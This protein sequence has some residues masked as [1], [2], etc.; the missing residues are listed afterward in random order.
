MESLNLRGVPAQT[1]SPAMQA[2]CHTV[3]H[4]G[5]AQIAPILILIFKGWIS[6]IL[7]NRID[8]TD[9]FDLALIALSVLWLSCTFGFQKQLLKYFSR[10]LYSLVHEPWTFHLASSSQGCEACCFLVSLNQK[11]CIHHT[12]MLYF[13]KKC[14]VWGSR[15][16]KNTSFKANF[17]LCISDVEG[18]L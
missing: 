15:I 5:S 13:S 11:Y 17:F 8:K 9:V 3:W 4:S 7:V 12:Y 14:F 2:S 18:Q 16:S 10:H 1:E 6:W